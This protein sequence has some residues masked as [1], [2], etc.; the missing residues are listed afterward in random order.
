MNQAPT[1]K[2]QSWRTVP[3]ISPIIGGSPF[4]ARYKVRATKLTSYSKQKKAK[5]PAT[6]ATAIGHEFLLTKSANQANVKT[7]GQIIATRKND[8]LGL[9]SGGTMEQTND[10]MLQSHTSN[11]TSVKTA[12]RPFPRI[13]SRGIPAADRVADIITI[14][15]TNGTTTHTIKN[16]R[17][18]CTRLACRKK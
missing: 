1:G 16:S 6:T 9:K 5:I 14:G 18:I 4:S 13:C 11:T 17:H 7:K 2:N 15:P 3:E 8:S 10:P 12:R